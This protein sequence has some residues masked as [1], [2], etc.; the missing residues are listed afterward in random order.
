MRNQSDPAADSANL[1]SRANAQA[2]Q[3]VDRILTILD[4][5][6]SSESGEKLA[7]L[8]R[9]LGAPKT[10]LVGLLA[11]MI[12]SGYLVRNPDGLYRLG[13]RM[14]SL[15]MR[16]VGSLNLAVLARPVLEWLEEKTEETCLLGALAPDG[17]TAM[18]I[19]KVESRSALRYT[20]SLGEHRELYCTAIGKLLLAYMPEAQQRRYLQR[21]RLQ[22]HTPDTI[23]SSARL[24]E[25]L[26]EI[27]ST[28]LSRT[29][30]ERVL[31]A[32][33]ISAPVFG[34]QGE[35][36]V[37]IVIAGP[38]ERIRAN[39]PLQIRLLREAAARLTETLAGKPPSASRR[40]Q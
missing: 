40:A 19:D 4:L 32:S 2:P 12:N 9:V 37:G 34:F 38:S 28:G 20:V 5:L 23:V 18:Y 22:A 16:V 30:G 15:S 11:G 1:P 21:T 27:R 29:R 24:L 35:L 33:A 8:A 25:D 39:E 7:D 6:A 31:C 3:S 36:L 17:N 13:P 10:S 26:A 14:Y